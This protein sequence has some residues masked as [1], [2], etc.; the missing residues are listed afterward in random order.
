MTLRGEVLRL[1]RMATCDRSPPDPE[2]GRNDVLAEVPLQA[3]IA[4]AVTGPRETETK[5][6]V[7]LRTTTPVSL[8][9]TSETV[10]E[11]C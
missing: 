10:S 3:A 2:A 11:A 5:V 4:R 9:N 8:M 1:A 7:T 6:S